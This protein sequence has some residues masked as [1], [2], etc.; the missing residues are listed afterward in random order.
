LTQ[1]RATHATTLVKAAEPLPSADNAPA[2]LERVQ[3]EE[4]W[5]F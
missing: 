1:L 3:P 4:R 2:V 5:V